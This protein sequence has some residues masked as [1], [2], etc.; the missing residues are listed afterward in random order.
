MKKEKQKTIAGLPVEEYFAKGHR[1]CAGCGAAI[2]MRHITRATGK[3]TI[4]AQATGCMEVV[5]TPYP[6]TAWKIPWIHAAFEN[7]SAVASGVERALKYKK[8]D[9]NVLI[10]GGDGGTFDIGFQSLSGAMERGH[11]V[12]YVVYDNEAYMNT[13][14]QRSGATPF[15]GATTTSPAGKKIPGKQEP[16]KPLPLI[17]AAHGLKYVATATISMPHDLYKKVKKAI[18]T[19][20]PAFVHV[21]CPC[22][23]G[24]K[25]ASNIT[26]D[27]A[28]K[29]VKSGITPIYE[30]ED[31]NLK[32]T[33]RP[34]KLEPID[35]YLNMQG[36]FKHIKGDLLKEVQRYVD[37]RFNFLIELEK[38][39]KVFDVLFR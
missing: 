13:G 34:E 15:L 39:E 6:E 1:A 14:I 22:I 35:E 12:T 19:K 8:K 25:M 3:N 32:F 37:K 38:K 5:S 36:R 11:N 21:F 20:G 30:I 17:M 4:I 10:I 27:L 23:P 16:K 26:V 29:A 9:T 28:E 18:E 7:A 2:A 31:G 33:V 24:W